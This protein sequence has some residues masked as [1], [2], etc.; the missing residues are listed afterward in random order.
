MWEC[1]HLEKTVSRG[2][3]LRCNQ[4]L[5][6][7]SANLIKKELSQ[8]FVASR[9]GAHGNARQNLISGP[10]FPLCQTP[11]LSKPYQC[12]IYLSIHDI[13]TDNV[14]AFF[15]IPVSYEPCRFCI[16]F[17]DRSLAKSNQ[18]GGCLIITIFVRASQRLALKLSWLSRRLEV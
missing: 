2:G 10:V 8:P 17:P 4:S 5:E 12:Y 7:I 9:F 16:V 11:W 13:S 15:S 1:F 6:V 18:R 14:P 3:V